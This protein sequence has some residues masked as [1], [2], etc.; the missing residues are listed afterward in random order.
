VLVFSPALRPVCSKARVVQKSDRAWSNDDLPSQTPQ[1]MVP[2]SSDRA[3][4]MLPD[5]LPVCIICRM[6]EELTLGWITPSVKAISKTPAK[7]NC[8]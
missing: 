3:W 8:R 6:G 7:P 5:M 4:A 1:K 2:E